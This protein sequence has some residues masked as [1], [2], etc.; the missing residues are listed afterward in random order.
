MCESGAVVITWQ[1]S[2][3]AICLAVTSRLVYYAAKN[4]QLSSH[5][6]RPRRAPP[7]CAVLLTKLLCYAAPCAL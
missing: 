6:R 5:Y 4:K 3:A 7:R 2:R 1:R